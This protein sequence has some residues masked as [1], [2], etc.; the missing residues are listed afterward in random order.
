M[1]NKISNTVRVTIIVVI[2][3]FLINSIRL[4]NYEN[5][6]SALT[7]II[8]IF[9]PKIL[10]RLFKLNIPSSL[11]IFYILLLFFGK[12]LGGDNYYYSVFPYY[13]K[14]LHI[15]YA[16]FASLISIFILIKTNTYNRKNIIFNMVFIISFSLGSEVIWEFLEFMSD[17]ILHQNNQRLETGII[18][19][20]IDLLVTFF[21]SL[22]FLADYIIEVK[23]N[24]QGIINKFIKNI[25]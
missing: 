6:L 11:E 18:D 20:M 14:I 2:A 19:T 15:A 23:F 4:Q 8:L 9:I 12:Y 21:T 25:Y 10:T 17:K 1:S 24:K 22:I 5:I 13:D 16:I 7:T 3:C